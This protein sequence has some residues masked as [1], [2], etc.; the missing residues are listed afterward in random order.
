MLHS[1]VETVH[2]CTIRLL[3][4]VRV[5]ELLHKSIQ[6]MFEADAIVLLQVQ[7]DSKCCLSVYLAFL[8]AEL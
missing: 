3:N 1:S 7:R 6:G 2:S 4:H 5:V 8:S